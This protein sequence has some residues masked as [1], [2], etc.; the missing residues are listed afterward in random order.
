[1]TPS[2]SFSA[3][4]TRH[5]LVGL[6]ANLGNRAGSLASAL[7]WIG[8]TKKA[9]IVRRSSWIETDPVGGPAGQPAF[10]NG[11][12]ILE[13]R[14]QPSEL[15]EML[16]ECERAHGRTRTVKDGP[17]TL[18]LD[19]LLMGNLIV[20]SAGITLPHPRM[21]ARRFVL[22]P[23]A[24]IAPDWLHPSSG[25]TIA[26]LL[27]ALD[28]TR[29]WGPAPGRELVGRTAFVAGSSSG[30]GR[31]IAQELMLAGARVL[32]HGRRAELLA[33]NLESLGHGHIAIEADL[34]LPG[35]GKSLAEKVFDLAP[36]TDIWIQNAGADILTGS[37]RHA[38][39]EE[40][41]KSL[42]QVDM[43][44][45][46]EAC[47]AAGRHLSRRGNGVILTIGWDQAETG[48]EGDSGQL[49][50]ATKAGVMAF[51]K[52]LAVDLAPKVRVNGIAPGWVRTAWGNQAS[53]EWQKRAE[54]ETLLRRWGAPQ[55]IAS[56]A[57][58]LS[59]PGGE[60]M[61]GQIIRVNG[62]AVRS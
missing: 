33:S 19:L 51:T 50:G 11:A 41:L 21:H 26:N 49:F 59:G 17:R 37:G 29:S 38:S 60:W 44:A 25:K 62:G 2:E 54:N 13:T 30:I 20:D 42:V 40:K 6:G 9:E 15:M 58:Y 56:C 39:F 5:A 4:K 27:A 61:T 46:M 32:I 35:A 57:R 47:R 55:D 7:S 28:G 16:L 24:E 45:C 10:L 1:L 12:A 34:S 48:M 43:V 3:A 23:A 52:S 18:D 8:N 14:L 53:E 22:A 31:T 36:E